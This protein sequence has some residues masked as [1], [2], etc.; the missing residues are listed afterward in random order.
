M[1]LKTRKQD[2]VKNRKTLRETLRALS[3]RKRVHEITNAWK[4]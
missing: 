2:M 3:R 4:D 1:A